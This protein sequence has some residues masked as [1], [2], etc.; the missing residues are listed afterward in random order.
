MQT[1]TPER[2][3]W[4]DQRISMWHRLC[5]FTCKA[6]DLDFV[7]LE[8]YEELNLAKSVAIIE[9]KRKDAPKNLYQ[10]LQVKALT[11][12][13]NRANLPVFITYYTDDCKRFVV[14]AANNWAFVKLKRER[15][16]TMTDEKYVMFLY[17]LRGADKVP[18]SVWKD[19]KNAD[20]IKPPEPAPVEEKP[21]PSTTLLTAKKFYQQSLFDF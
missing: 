4:R 14:F 13:G 12:L 9:Y 8:Y 6:T 20:S 10:T 7:L 5:G 19:I 2:T 15:R 3:G 11:D 18:N 17:K 21:M 16:V 1:V